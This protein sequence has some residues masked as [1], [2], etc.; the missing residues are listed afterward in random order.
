MHFSEVK[1]WRGV[2]IRGGRQVENRKG[3]KNVATC[4]MRYTGLGAG[5][6]RYI[7]SVLIIILGDTCYSYFTDNHN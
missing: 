3:T 5:N 6:F 1:L 2:G 4:L 7:I